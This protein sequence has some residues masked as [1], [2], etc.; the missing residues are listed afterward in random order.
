MT[1]DSADARALLRVAPGDYVAE[2]T[3]LAKE[4]RAAGHRA[5]AGAYQALKRPNL[6]MWAV[7][8]A[9]DDADAVRAV[10]TATA[11]L[12]KV[13]A[14][15]SDAGAVSKA[16]QHRRK[17][18]ESLVDAAVKALARFEPGA[19]ARRAEIRG[20]VD[21]LSRHEDLADGWIHGTLRDLPDDSWG[22][23]A[24]ADLEVTAGARSALPSPVEPKGRTA[25]A[26]PAPSAA[27]P[28]GP[29]RAERAANVRQARHDVTEARRAVGSAERRL[30]GARKALRDAEKEMRLAEKDHDLAERHHQAAATRLQAAEDG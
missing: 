12:A 9:A 11:D 16:S 7:L 13:Q 8:A 3:R 25:K 30:D 10:V 29:T 22:F 2:R 18:L 20:I 21:Q 17:A 6:S 14:G 28:Q 27:P 1:T 5:V 26:A 15:G 23:G 4:A 24:F 19:E